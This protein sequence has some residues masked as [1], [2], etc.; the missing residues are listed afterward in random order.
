MEELDPHLSLQRANPLTHG[1]RGDSKLHSGAR[2][3]AVPGAG[4]EDAER[5][6]R[7]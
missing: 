5:I 4:G 7:G 3:I 6:K 2:E 1:G